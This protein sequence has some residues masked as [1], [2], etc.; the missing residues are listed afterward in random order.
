M[1]NEGFWWVL[2]AGLILLLFAGVAFTIV[3]IMLLFV[4]EWRKS[5]DR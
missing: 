5:R 3:K 4:R 1:G 2:V